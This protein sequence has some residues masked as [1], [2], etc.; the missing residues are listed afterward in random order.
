M[1]SRPRFSPSAGACFGREGRVLN[2]FKPW[3]SPR[4]SHVND[5]V[6][7]PWV[8]LVF[9]EQVIVRVLRRLAENNPYV[10]YHFPS[11]L[12]DP[13]PHDL[14]ELADGGLNHMTVR[15]FEQLVRDGPFRVVD[16]H[17]TGY[18][19]LLPH[20]LSQPVRAVATLPGIRELCGGWVITVLAKG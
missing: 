5:W 4:G 16:H 17:L 20:G 18:G 3:L 19:E 15:R 10:E 8:H 7:L 12:A 13:L 14:A 1:L 2:V 11:L 9:D 6:P